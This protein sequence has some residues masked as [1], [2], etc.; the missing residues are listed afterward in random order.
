MITIKFNDSVI[1]RDG[2]SAVDLKMVIIKNALNAQKSF[3]NV[4]PRCDKFII[5]KGY[6]VSYTKYLKA[7][8]RVSRDSI[9]SVIAEEVISRQ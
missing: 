8:I 3:F 2:S 4:A 5:V 9:N 1:K 6:R 7:F